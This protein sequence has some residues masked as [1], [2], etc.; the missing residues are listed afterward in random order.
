MARKGKN[1]RRKYQQQ[2]LITANQ[3]IIEPKATDLASKLVKATGPRD[4]RGGSSRERL[5][6]GSYGVGFRGPRGFNSPRDLVSKREREPGLLAPLD[7]NA[8]QHGVNGSKRHAGDVRYG[9]ETFG[10]DYAVESPSDTV[11][12]KRGKPGRWKKV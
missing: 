2:A 10:Y 9:A 6:L 12:V 1:E 5:K 7:V 3:S 8:P 4:S 11:M